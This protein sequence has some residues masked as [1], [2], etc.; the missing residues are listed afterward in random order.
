MIAILAIL[1]TW[2]ITKLYY[3]REMLIHF[4]ELEDHG[5]MTA[6][7]V[8]CSQYIVISQEHMRNPF[9]CTACK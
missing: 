7:C 9:Y 3:T 8:Q 5:L 6:Q 1:I 2:Y 4:P